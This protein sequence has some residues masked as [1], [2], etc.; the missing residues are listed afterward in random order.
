[1]SAAVARS[2]PEPTA[3]I[4]RQIVKAALAVTN[5][6]AASDRNAEAVSLRRT[7]VDGFLPN[8]VVSMGM[9]LGNQIEP[10]LSD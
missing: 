5:P 7:R 8:R 9:H 4:E 2:M 6:E 3:P 10:T 1:M